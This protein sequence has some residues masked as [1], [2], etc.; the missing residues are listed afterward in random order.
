[1][2]PPT[3]HPVK[4]DAS[5]ERP[6]PN[7]Q[8]TTNELIASMHDIA[9][10]VFEHSG[11]ARRA[12]HAKGHALLVGEISILADL[13]SVLKQGLCAAPAVYPVFM[14]FSTIPGDMLDDSISVPRGLGIKIIGVSGER[15]PDFLEDLTQDFLFANGPVFSAPTL[16]AFSHTAKALALTT[17]QP[18]ALKKIVSTATRGLEAVVEAFGGASPLLR[19]LGAYP[20][21][22]VLSD[23]YFTQGALR[24]GDFVAKL[25]IAPV[26]SALVAIKDRHLDLSHPDAL[27]EAAN[28]F[29]ADQTA[30]WELRAQLC[31]DVSTMPIEDASVEWPQKE[32]PYIAIARLRAAPQVAWSEAKADAAEDVISFN[33][34]RGLAAHRPLGAIM[35]ARRAV[36][37]AS[38]Q[39]RAEANRV[40]M[41]D[42]RSAA[43]LPKG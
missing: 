23:E 34:W 22:N 20:P 1:M 15:L 33:P 31:A 8:Q 43:D 14:R 37:P 42:P 30:E 13:P 28:A 19:T 10:T 41:R 26:S 12:V 5:L 11:H 27:R 4:Y 21:T 32:S 3:A 2:T 18:Q 9:D 29:M 38:A 6:E 16:E 17:D 35:R 36:Y 40:T 25:Q 7:E 24:Y 39:Y